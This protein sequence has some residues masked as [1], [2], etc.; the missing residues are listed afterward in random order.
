MLNDKKQRKK[1]PTFHHLPENRAKKLKQSWVQ[2][3][4]IKSQWKAQ[5]RKE[6]I[7]SSRHVL[8][9]H[10]DAAVM[11]GQ[12]D[13]G[14]ADEGDASS[15]EDGS[16]RGQNSEEDS[17]DEDEVPAHSQTISSRGK[18]VSKRGES[19][20]RGRGRGRGGFHH[21][22]RQERGGTSS[23]HADGEMKPSLR[24]LQSQAYSRASLHSRADRNQ[25]NVRNTRG[26]DRGRG[27]QR[28]GQRRRGQP[29][30]RLRMNAMLEKIKRDIV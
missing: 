4:K 24:D 22:D 2:V 23:K 16:I 8:S 17:G 15:V 18:S 14:A 30:M 11:P 28:G 5:K 1:P 25:T 26:L 10:G 12:D 21:R 27:T 6:G 7:Q 20:G 19:V 3:Q 9:S 13:D 29:D